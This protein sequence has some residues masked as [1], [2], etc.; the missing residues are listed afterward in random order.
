MKEL[1]SNTPTAMLSHQHAS[2]FAY[3]WTKLFQPQ[4]LEVARMVWSDRVDH[5]TAA[6][7]HAQNKQ[8]IDLENNKNFMK[9][10]LN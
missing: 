4:M 7:S 5:V 8:T 1:D 3:E 6:V 9:Q 2:I 10:F